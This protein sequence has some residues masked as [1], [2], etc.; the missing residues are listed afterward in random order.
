VAI[1]EDPGDMSG[2]ENPEALDVLREA[3]AAG[4]PK[5]AAS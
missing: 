1:G 2:A 3:V 5:A 4:A